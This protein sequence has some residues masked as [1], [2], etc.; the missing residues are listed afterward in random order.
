MTK[1]SLI[2]TKEGGAK[3]RE[4]ATDDTE[5]EKRPVNE[6]VERECDKGRDDRVVQ[7]AGSPLD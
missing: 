2:K 6:E 5:L 7:M 4:D 1:E 3:G